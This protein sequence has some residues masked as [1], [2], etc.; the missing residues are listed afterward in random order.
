MTA[1]FLLS[2]CM[3]LSE[4]LVECFQEELKGVIS[5]II[6]CMMKNIWGCSMCI[7]VGLA[8]LNLGQGCIMY[9]M[10]RE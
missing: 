1:P 2:L 3:S 4:E 8:W 7:T 6:G 5:S 10:D 9:V